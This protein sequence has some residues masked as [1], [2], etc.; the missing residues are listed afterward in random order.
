[1][2]NYQL[3]NNKT[4]QIEDI[5]EDQIISK[6]YYMTHTLP[7]NLPENELLKLKQNISRIHNLTPLYDPYTDNLYLIT[8]QELY[9]YV[10]ELYFRFPTQK[11]INDIKNKLLTDKQL[12]KTIKDNN[13]KIL[14]KD[15]IYRYTLML[16]FLDY[17]DIQILLDTYIK[18]LYN[19]QELGKSITLCK[20]PS[21]SPKFNHIKPYFSKDEIINMSLNMGLIRNDKQITNNKV[22]ELCYQISD[23]DITF[24]NLINHHNHIVKSRMIGL[25]QYYSI[26]GFVL[27]NQY[28]RDLTSVNNKY[29]NKMIKSL[30]K[31]ITSAPKLDKKY[32]LYRFIDND[33]FLSHLNEGDIFTERGFMSTTR[34]PFYKQDD[35]TFGWILLKIHLPKK[36]SVLCIE[37][38]SNF[39]NEEEITLPPGT[40][41]KLLSKGYKDNIY[42]HTDKVVQ[43]KIK[44]IYEFK[45]IK[46]PEYD[47]TF[48]HKQ[49]KYDEN[50]IINTPLDI[51]NINTSINLIDF[52]K[53]ERTNITNLITINEKMI[54]FVDNYT[55]N[56]NQFY[57][58]IGDTK[59]LMTAETYNSS[60]IYQPFYAISTNKGVCIYC[61]FNNHQL[62]IIEF[63]DNSMIVNYGLKYITVENKQ[64]IDSYDFLNF[65]S[66]IAYYFNIFKIIIYSNYMSCD[67]IDYNLESNIVNIKYTKIGGVFCLDIYNYIKHKTKK[68]E[69]V[70][71]AELRPMFN[72]SLLDKFANI[73][74]KQI[75]K[76]DKDRRNILYQLYSKIYKTNENKGKRT[77]KNFYLWLVKNN[78]YYIDDLIQLLNII[79]EFKLNNP[80]YNDHYVFYPMTYLYNR[81]IIQN[82][83]SS[84]NYIWDD[85]NNFKRNIFNRSNDV[86]IRDTRN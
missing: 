59:Y 9:R 47:K 12:F 71:M 27:F 18:T 19:T 72:Y 62:F 44:T 16:Q 76:K 53:L 50:I 73:K 42:Y 6:L 86:R 66:H 49:K 21:F 57:S 69:N 38:V 56:F 20:R 10:F 46:T 52:I 55:N 75:L 78:C 54:Y 45:V 43:N 61:I 85:V 25:I 80:F 37:T 1:M 17:F 83:P 65:L 40:Q 41:L 31:L 5:P 33:N 70:I 7:T 35:L 64:I 26:Q 2:N 82:I 15:T 22:R 28:L 39:P 48:V 79:P 24:S 81:N 3:L 58:S 23:N 67:Y 29:L 68:Y 32:I 63:T 84:N 36:M 51:T 13:T 77:I 74:I 4:N 34:N 60:T 30:I 8:N 11:F 14:A